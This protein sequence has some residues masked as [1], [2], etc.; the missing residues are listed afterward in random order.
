MRRERTLE[1][2]EEDCRMIIIGLTDVRCIFLGCGKVRGWAHLVLTFRSRWGTHG[3][4]RTQK[5]KTVVSCEILY[6][7]ALPAGENFA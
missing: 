1:H 3:I 4:R 2:A 5:T 7:D 6:G